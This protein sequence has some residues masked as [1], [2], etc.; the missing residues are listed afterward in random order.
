MRPVNTLLTAS[1]L[2]VAFFT[3]PAS[4]QDPLP[5]NVQ[6]AL[7]KTEIPVEALSA[8][9]MPLE[10]G[11]TALNYSAGLAMSPA[12]TMKLLTTIIALE[13]L[14]PTF[15]W[16]TQILSKAVVKNKSLRG[17]LYLR[18]GGAPDLSW[19]R[20]G[21]MLRSLR[22]L[23]IQNIV[24]NIVLDR[25][26]FQPSRMDL[27]VPPFDETPDAYYNVI[28]DAL[29]IES[30]LSRFEIATNHNQ[31]HIAL[32][33]PMANIV[34]KNRLTLD[35]K[36]CS[37][38]EAGWQTPIITSNRAQQTRITLS[39]SFPRDCKIS[40]EL[41]TLERNIYIEQLI[42]K[43]WQ[44]MGGRWNGYIS[45]GQVPDN[46]SLLVERLSDTLS[47][48][49][50]VINKRSDNAMARLLYLTLGSEFVDR[51]TYSSSLQAADAHVRQW[52]QNHGI[53]SESLVLENGSGLSR[54]ERISAQQMA[55]LLQAAA[56]SNWFPEFLTSL[57]IAAVDGTMRKRLKGSSAE[58]RARVKTG[59]LKDTSAIAG[60]V[61]DI[62]NKM[63]IVVA[64]V[65][66]PKSV[67]ARPILDEVI[68][69]VANG[70]SNSERVN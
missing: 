32:S 3:P 29:L 11:P 42:R 5:A 15:R 36:P 44:E 57:P 17:D 50:K 52:L 45:N 35:D 34:L 6:A 4:A 20:L 19:E 63:W 21:H 2:V 55:A 67:Q 59:T 65:N 40:T 10:A 47:D 31:F 1:L 39:G 24:G 46:A 56:N 14:G 41:N 68:N 30:N 61:R 64:I 33:P 60:Y 12:S 13:E 66:H 18:G 48:N 28:P 22:A 23:G 38:W 8:L 27:N 25:T 16:K 49:I 62:H 43:L 26:Y 69:W 70:A 51:K 9:V 58:A 54:L 37:E 53:S 7:A